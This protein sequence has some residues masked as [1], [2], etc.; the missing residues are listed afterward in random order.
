MLNLVNART[1]GEVEGR[2]DR[3]ENR[4]FGF[5]LKNEEETKAETHAYNMG[6]YDGWYANDKRSV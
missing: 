2:A 6:Y 1:V 3:K 4:M 5:S